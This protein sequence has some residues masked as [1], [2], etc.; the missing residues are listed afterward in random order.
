MVSSDSFRRWFER[1]LAERFD[2]CWNR[3]PHYGLSSRAQPVQQT[4]ASRKECRDVHRHQCR[5]RTRHQIAQVLPKIRRRF[6]I[7]LK[8]EDIVDWRLPVATSDIGREIETA[9]NDPDYISGMPVHSGASQLI[10]DLYPTHRVIV[11]TARPESARQLTDRWLWKNRLWHN[12]LTY[13]KE[14]S[15]ST[16][17]TAILV[18]D[19]L[20]NVTEYLRNTPGV[21][22]LVDRP[23]N[24]SRT[25]VAEQIKNGRLYIVE[26]LG[27]IL[28]TVDA[29]IKDV[30]S[31]GCQPGRARRFC[32]GTAFT[33]GQGRR[34]ADQQSRTR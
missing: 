31:D 3:R 15:K 22:I 14:A 23:W 34:N 24:Q 4:P 21:A 2:H 9:F 17:E 25:E 20:G 19:Y 10:K 18:D 33:I 11:L 5:R 27:D 28:Q 16:R 26:A 12:E 1:R 7:E 29:R 6:G 8:Y 13:V 32:S 30:D